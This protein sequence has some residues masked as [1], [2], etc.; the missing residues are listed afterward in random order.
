MPERRRARALL[1]LRPRFADVACRTTERRHGRWRRHLTRCNQSLTLCIVVGHVQTRASGLVCWNPAFR[2]LITAFRESCWRG[3]GGF[4]HLQIAIIKQI[5]PENGCGGILR[6]NEWLRDVVEL[7][8]IQ[9]RRRWI[10][11]CNSRRWR[12]VFALFARICGPKRGADLLDAIAEHL[13]RLFDRRGVRLCNAVVPFRALT[14]I[15][16]LCDAAEAFQID[17]VQ[18]NTIIAFS[19]ED[20]LWVLRRVLLVVKLLLEPL[21]IEL[22]EPLGAHLRLP[23]AEF[24]QRAPPLVV[25]AVDERAL[26]LELSVIAALLPCCDAR[27]LHGENGS[28][29]EGQ[30][31]QRRDV[32]LPKVLGLGD[33][34]VARDPQRAQLRDRLEDLEH[35]RIFES[36]VADVDV[37]ELLALR[38][39]LEVV[40]RLQL[41]AR[42]V[43]RR[44]LRQLREPRE[45]PDAVV[46][47][48]EC[49]ELLETLEVLD[50]L[51]QTAQAHERREVLDLGQAIRLEPQ[52]LQVE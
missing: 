13:V 39:L 4:H 18:G 41:I 36:V 31:R 27:S 45:R 30:L 28:I 12:C 15:L 16:L 33:H 49:V 9:Q 10:H 50:A 47:E 2:L 52:R 51:D 3:G 46:A 19:F 17:L 20:C 7:F 6:F 21:V 23:V 35:A 8:S 14:R 1:Q 26:G 5:V 32:E 34:G 48:V 44:E 25:L 22:F 29:Q 11:C 43:E 37:R 38:E 42:Q 40:V 24:L